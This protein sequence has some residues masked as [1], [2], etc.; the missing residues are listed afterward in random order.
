MC[1]HNF[2]SRLG[3][4]AVFGIAQEL[5]DRLID[6][7]GAV[8]HIPYGGFVH[9]VTPVDGDLFRIVSTEVLDDAGVFIQY[10]ARR[11]SG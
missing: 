5:V 10:G 3:E 6:R 9:S 8:G 7:G 1:L 4:Q 11:S 2:I